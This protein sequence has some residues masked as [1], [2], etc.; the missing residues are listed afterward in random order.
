MSLAK[1][2]GP[3]GSRKRTFEHFFE[4]QQNDGCWLWIG[5]K[6]STKNLVYGV[7]RES[8]KLRRAHLVYW[9]RIKGKVPEGLELDHLCRNTLCVRPEHLEPVTHKVNVFRGVSP[10]ALNAK[11]THAPCGHPY[12]GQDGERRYCK[13]CRTKWHREYYHRKRKSI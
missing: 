7:Y 1:N 5:A 11:K 9:E 12:S 13:P 6:Q 3:G 2:G 10:G 4:R 8:G